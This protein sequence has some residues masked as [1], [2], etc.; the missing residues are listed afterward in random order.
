MKT[1]KRAARFGAMGGK[2]ILVTGG[3]QGIGKAIVRRFLES[4][5]DV[6]FVDLDEDAGLET[7]K[8]FSASGR[9]RF[10]AADVSNEEHVRSAVAKAVGEFGGLDVLV[11]NAA[12]GCAHVPPTDLTLNNWNRVLAV[13]LTGPFLCAKH[14][15]PYLR[16]RHG[17]VVN[18]AS[19]RALMSEVNTEAYSAS[20][21]GLV[22]LTHALAVSLGP[23]IRVN[24]ISPGWIETAEWKVRAKRRKPVHSEA[25]RLQHP[26]GR[27]GKPDDIAAMVLH[28][29]TDGGFITG[30]NFLIDG[31]MTH[32]MIYV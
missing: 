11:N 10:A 24:C 9:M 26:C 12:T 2:A 25:D 30:A 3:G 20:K 8:E 27:V 21:G 14:A 5:A 29:A 17:L 32:K 23:G 28:L 18:I 19:T 22:A 7:L 15:A 4:G 16:K 6:F 31:G 1:K 13:N